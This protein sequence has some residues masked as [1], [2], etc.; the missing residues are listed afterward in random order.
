MQHYWI[1]DPE[2]RRIECYRADAGAYVAA[3]ELE[4][5]AMLEPPDWPGLTISLADLWR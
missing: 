3:R 2:A 5:D 4:G 1:V